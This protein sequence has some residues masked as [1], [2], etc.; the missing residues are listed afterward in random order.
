MRIARLALRHWGADAV[1]DQR[2]EMHFGCPFLG[3][4]ILEQYDDR[5]CAEDTLSAESA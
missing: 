2:A 1:V 4:P 3:G 5:R